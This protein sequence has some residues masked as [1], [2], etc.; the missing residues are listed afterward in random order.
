MC[1]KRN[2]SVVIYQC[3]VWHRVTN[4][5]DLQI[6]LHAVP[7]DLYMLVAGNTAQGISRIPNNIHTFIDIT[8]IEEL[9]IVEQTSTSLTIGSLVTLKDTLK[10]MKESVSMDGFDYLNDLLEHFELVANV[11][12]R[13]VS[14]L[15]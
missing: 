12:V 14:H 5:P 7:D 8:P 4:I 11:P 6:A 9:Y 1:I 3:K 13:N 10:L 15:L 2:S